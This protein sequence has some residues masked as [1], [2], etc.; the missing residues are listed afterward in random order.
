MRELNSYEVQ[1]VSGGSENSGQISGYS[2]AGA[3]M[4]VL[5]TGAA[6]STAPISGPVIGLA[7]GAAAGLAIAQAIVNNSSSGS[8]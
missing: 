2:G 7:I 5:G 1:Q 3:I 8:N 4:A 6:I